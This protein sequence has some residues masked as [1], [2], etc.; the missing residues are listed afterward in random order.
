MRNGLGVGAAAFAIVAVLGVALFGGAVAPTAAAAPQKPRNRRGRHRRCRC[1]P[2]TGRRSPAQR[3]TTL[4]V[5]HAYDL[6]KTRMA[7]CRRGFMTSCQR[8][9]GIE[10][11]CDRFSLFAG[12][13]PFRFHRSLTRFDEIEVLPR[14]C[15]APQRGRTLP[16]T[17][18]PFTVR[19]TKPADLQGLLRADEGTRTLDLLHGKQTL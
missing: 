11:A 14:D 8:S 4:C 1:G 6:L 16:R 9:T 5:S 7:L 12:L 10:A 2:H 19:T 18:G 3:S 13:S 15:R 17:S